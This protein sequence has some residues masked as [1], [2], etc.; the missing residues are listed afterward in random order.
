MLLRVLT[1]LLQCEER[2]LSLV[3]SL[4]AIWIYSVLHQL[5][6]APW[7]LRIKEQQSGL[8]W[9]PQD[10]PPSFSRNFVRVITT[11]LEYKSRGSQRLSLA[12]V[13][14]T[15]SSPVGRPGWVLLEY[16]AGLLLC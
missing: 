4:L 2:P 12:R 9:A 13:P 10:E 15:A 11:L 8:A 5:M 14:I 16:N 6:Y 3:A 1:G 7:A